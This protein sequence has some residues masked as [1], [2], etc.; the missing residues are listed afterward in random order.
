[1]PLLPYNAKDTPSSTCMTVIDVFGR[2]RQGATLRERHTSRIHPTSK[3][4][5]EH[6]HHRLLKLG[7]VGVHDLR[8][9]QLDARAVDVTTDPCN[10]V[11]ALSMDQ[12]STS[13]AP[14]AVV[15]VDADELPRRIFLTSRTRY[16]HAL[17]SSWLK[18]AACRLVSTRRAP[19]ALR[20]TLDQAIL[21]A[22]GGIGSRY[23]GPDTAPFCRSAPCLRQRGDLMEAIAPE[24][25]SGRAG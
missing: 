20:G 8:L 5:L 3:L 22:S 9:R 19:Y 17:L 12:L 18:I 16:T 2:L 21:L 11:T 14:H 10:V 6:R 23:R 13:S 15:F 25:A 1:M 4:L 7:L 24:V